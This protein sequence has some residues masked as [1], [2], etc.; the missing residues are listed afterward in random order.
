M[1]DEKLREAFGT[2]AKASIQRF[3]VD[4]IGLS[5]EKFILGEKD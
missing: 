4:T 3:D 2:K 1:K 5:F